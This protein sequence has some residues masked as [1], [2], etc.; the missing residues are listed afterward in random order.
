MTVTQ[1][2]STNV[3]VSWSE[4]QC[5]DRSGAVTHYLCGI[6]SGVIQDVTTND[7]INIQAWDHSHALLGMHVT[8]GHPLSHRVLVHMW[9]TEYEPG[10]SCNSSLGEL[11]SSSMAA[12]EYGRC[13]DYRG[14]PLSNLLCD[15]CSVLHLVVRE[16]GVPQHTQWLDTKK[17]HTLSDIECSF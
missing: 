3:T 1:V 7:I 10:S 16:R 8:G 13:F 15:K 9:C 11:Q 12:G 6:C 4:V 2:N 17:L 5:F 14:T